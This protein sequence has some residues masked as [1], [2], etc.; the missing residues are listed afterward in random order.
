[1]EKLSIIANAYL[2]TTKAEVKLVEKHAMLF[3]FYVS[4]SQ[5][6]LSRFREP[7]NI[8]VIL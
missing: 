6:A 1:M 4:L 3:V 2:Q 5:V 7:L 8:V